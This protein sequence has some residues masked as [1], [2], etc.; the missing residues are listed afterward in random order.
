MA[1]GGQPAISGKAIADGS[2]D[3]GDVGYLVI[4]QPECFAQERML[5]PVP[6]EAWHVTARHDGGLAHADGQFAEQIYGLG[7]RSL[8]PDDFH[9]RGN[10]RRVQEVESGEGLRAL[11]A[12][13]ESGDRQPGGIGGQERTVAEPGRDQR[14]QISL[15]LSVFGH[16]LD[17]ELT[18]AEGSRF[19]R[20][21]ADV[22]AS[23]FRRPDGAFE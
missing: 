15:D 21:C 4:D 3:G 13:C 5:Q 2:V 8:S 20:A 19:K 7:G 11:H 16:G 10:V 22:L 12:S 17:D 1:N 9:D 6:D 23:Q 14:V 18:I